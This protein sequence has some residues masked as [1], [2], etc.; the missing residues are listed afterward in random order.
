M[1]TIFLEY[2]G[3]HYIKGSLL[4]LCWSTTSLEKGYSSFNLQQPSLCQ[5]DMI[6]FV[7]A[8]CPSIKGLFAFWI[9]IGWPSSKGRT[10]YFVHVG[11]HYI[12]MKL[13]YFINIGHLTRKGIFQSFAVVSHPYIKG[14]SFFW[15]ISAAPL[16]KEHFNFCLCQLPLYERDIIIWYLLATPVKKGNLELV[17]M[18]AAPL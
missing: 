5:R 12:K 8:G 14:T 18:L 1:R 9:C 11:C 15:E 6:F 10:L 16:Q 13:I 4:F 7:N 2:V 3:R 17:W